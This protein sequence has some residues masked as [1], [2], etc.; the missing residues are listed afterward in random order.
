M[1]SKLVL[2]AF[3]LVAIATLAAGVTWAVQGGPGSAEVAA[4]EPLPEGYLHFDEAATLEGL[5][6]VDARTRKLWE[7]NGREGSVLLTDHPSENW[8]GLI[9]EAF[10]TLATAQSVVVYC[11]TE[12]CGSSEPV[13]QKIKELGII[14]AERVFILAG[15][16]K[17]LK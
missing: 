14:P 8:D 6:W 3:A 13:A 10:P 17:S 2:E 7:R 16:W 9:A 15:G 12:S 1:F 4:T 5:V 11:A